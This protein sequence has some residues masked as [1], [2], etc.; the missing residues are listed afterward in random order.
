MAIGGRKGRKHS[1]KKGNSSE[2]GP[3]LP[4]HLAG[5]S[6]LYVGK[7]NIIRKSSLDDIVTLCVTGERKE[8]K[9]D[10]LDVCKRTKQSVDGPVI[11]LQS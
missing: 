1:G 6:Q 11:I 2:T 8:R 4:V 9:R 10:Q 7:L 3:I 5:L